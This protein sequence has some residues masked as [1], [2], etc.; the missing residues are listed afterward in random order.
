M[1]GP[2]GSPDAAIEAD[3][4]KRRVYTRSRG[5]HR[6]DADA[7]ERM[8]LRQIAEGLRQSRAQQRATD[9]VSEKTPTVAGRSS[10]LRADRPTGSDTCR[11]KRARTGVDGPGGSAKNTKNRRTR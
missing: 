10:R 9:T 6:Y 3:L 8:N 4:S 5:P 11:K 2:A 7:V 1:M